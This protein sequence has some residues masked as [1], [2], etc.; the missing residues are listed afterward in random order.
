MKTKYLFSFILCIFLFPT[1]IL[2][3]GSTGHRVIAEIAQ[4]N[5]SDETN[6][7]INNLLDSLP[8]AYWANWPDFIKSDKTG[9]WDHTFKWHYVNAPGNLSP[10]DYIKHLKKEKRENIYSEIPKL[11]KIIESASSSNEEKR[12]ALV[13]LIHLI[14]DAHQPMHLGRQEDLGGN[15]IQVTWFWQETNLHTVWDVKLI[16]YEKYSY[17]EYANILDILPQERKL[18]LIDADLDDWLYESHNLAN[19]IYSSV[20]NGDKLSY[21]YSY[22][23][24]Y[25]M[26]LQLQRAGLRLA[27]TLDKIFNTDN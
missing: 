23:Y 24:K 2:S 21:E 22:K 13:F 4:R 17:T 15:K 6:Q 14:G 16:D 5:I 19:E 11:E 7:K 12:I 8:M 27:A 1:D 3:W 26:E 25:I 20:N 10:K 18:E 9:T